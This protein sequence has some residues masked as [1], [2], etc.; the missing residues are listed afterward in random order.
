MSELLFLQYLFTQQYGTI[1]VA[2]TPITDP[3]T[4]TI[5]IVNEFYDFQFDTLLELGVITFEV[6]LDVIL[7]ELGIMTFEF[8][9]D[10]ILFY[11][12]LEVF[13]IQI[14]LLAKIL[15]T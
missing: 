10:V 4:I 14:E 11:V 8:G 15:L 7:L 2:I 9:L 3:T 6:E 12:E 1:T 13:E 5:I